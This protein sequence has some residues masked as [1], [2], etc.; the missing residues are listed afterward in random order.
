MA[1]SFFA[2]AAARRWS[3]VWG[4]LFGSPSSEL[5][6]ESSSSSSSDEDSS[7]GA[8]ASCRVLVTQRG[9][10]YGQGWERFA[11]TP[12]AER[13]AVSVQWRKILAEFLAALQGTSQYDLLQFE[14][15]GGEFSSPP[16]VGL[17]NFPPR[18]LP[19]G[20]MMRFY[21]G[22]VDFSIPI[23]RNLVDNVP[24]AIRQT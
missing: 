7:F 14:G 6:E 13:V 11:Y 18:P 9:E 19:P 4:F 5:S 23:N 16:R 1:A 8:W 22:D 20:A 24:P 21:V 17:L 2:F 15:I 12:H 3:R 10:R